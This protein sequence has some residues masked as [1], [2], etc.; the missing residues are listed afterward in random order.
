MSDSKILAC[1]NCGQKNRVQVVASGVPHCARCGSPLPWLVDI[2]SADFQS[3]VADSPLPVLADFWAP[4]CGPCRMVAPAVEKIAGDLAGKVKVV[5]INTDEQPE[6]QAR[7]GV[8]GIP[9]LVLFEDGKE[10]DRV[11]GARPAPALRSWLD[12]SLASVRR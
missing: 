9:T 5:K 1:P 11:I 6:L 7:F 12:E 10:K 2:S 3:G 4:W 8:R